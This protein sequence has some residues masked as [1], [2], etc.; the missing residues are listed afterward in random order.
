[1]KL[2]KVIN[3][4]FIIPQ[5]CGASA[6]V[7]QQPSGAVRRLSFIASSRVEYTPPSLHGSLYS[8]TLWVV[9]PDP[10]A[11]NL[12]NT[13]SKA[14]QAQVRVICNGQILADSGLVTVDPLTTVDLVADGIEG[15][16]PM[17]CEFSF[18][19]KKDDFRACAKIFTPPNGTD[20]LMIEAT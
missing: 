6:A 8:P 2:S 17:F 16:G 14:C 19:G 12:L 7:E 11:C 3:L 5:L 20:Q 1:M 18:E 9:Y 13:G 15:G 10:V 4:S